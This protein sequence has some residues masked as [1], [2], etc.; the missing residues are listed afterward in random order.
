ML[1]FFKLSG[2]G[3]DFLLIHLQKRPQEMP[4]SWLEWIRSACHRQDGVGADGVIFCGVNDLTSFWMRIF[5]SD[6]GE[7]RMCGN[8]LRC[9]ALY[10]A[11]Q[12]EMIAEQQFTIDLLESTHQAF[13]QSDGL[14]CVQIEVP[15]KIEP[16]TLKAE[17]RTFQGLL[18]DTGVPHFV[19]LAKKIFPTAL[20][21]A[22]IP[23][24]SWGAALRV[25][26]LWE[27]FGYRD[28]VNVTFVE[29]GQMNEMSIRTFER[30]VEAETLACGTGAAA[31]AWAFGDLKIDQA[32]CTVFFPSQKSALHLVTMNSE[33]DLRLWQAGPAHSAFHGFVKAPQ[34]SLGAFTSP[35]D[36][37]IKRLHEC[38]E[39]AHFINR[40]F[41]PFSS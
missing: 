2:A 24:E 4:K 17:G 40:V 5:N 41:S 19:V 22:Q 15:Q 30:G 10:F 9:T 11:C 34:D 1:P 6:G 12:S 3:N 31:A 27:D 28:G 16:I 21:L 14:P 25:S 23:I 20:K 29:S 7:A 26:R 37:V 13:L 18:I 32:P 38:S 33:A 36:A 39:P 8:G 35:S